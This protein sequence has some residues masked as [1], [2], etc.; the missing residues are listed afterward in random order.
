M[1]TARWWDSAERSPNVRLGRRRMIP[2]AE[3]GGR[4]PQSELLFVYAFVHPPNYIVLMI[5]GR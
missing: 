1:G 3:L 4:S 2:C 5:Y